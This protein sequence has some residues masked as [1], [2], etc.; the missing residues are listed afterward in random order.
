MPAYVLTGTPGCG[1]TALLRQLEVDGHRVVEEAA[2][3]VIALHQALGDPEPWRHPAF[4]DRVAGLQQRR[5]LAAEPG[6][7]FFDRSPVCTLALSRYAGV[8]ASDLLREQVEHAAG[9]Y[10][11]SVFFV[12]NLGFVQP[13]EAR[14]ITLPDA[15]RFEQIH[16]DT[17]LE[18]GYTLIEVPAA[19]LPDR[20]AHILAN[21]GE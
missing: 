2:T 17:Y 12:R 13:T 21:V 7:T 1:K 4:I 18:L 16:E 10:E 6:L 9:F 20:V 15:L 8:P 14:R 5:Q 19:G 3:D 11:R